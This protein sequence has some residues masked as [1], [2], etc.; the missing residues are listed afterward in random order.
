VQ[1][2][3]PQ[4]RHSPQYSGVFG[5]GRLQKWTI[6]QS[7][8]DLHLLPLLLSFSFAVA[9]EAVLIGCRVGCC[10]GIEEITAEITAC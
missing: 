3:P 5:S 8:L 2:V 9:M 1:P 10:V 4:I 7:R 6:L